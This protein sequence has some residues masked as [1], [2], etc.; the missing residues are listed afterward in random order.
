MLTFDYGRAELYEVG[1]RLRRL[2]RPF[3][4]MDRSLFV[5]APVIVLAM[6]WTRFTTD[7]IWLSAYVVGFIAWCVFAPWLHRRF[8]DLCVMLVMLDRYHRLPR[9]GNVKMKI[10]PDGITWNVARG[11]ISAS[12][13]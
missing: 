7:A 1:W 6:S 10:A 8:S 2:S 11:E 3:R 12:H 13:R 4:F 9:S 5:A